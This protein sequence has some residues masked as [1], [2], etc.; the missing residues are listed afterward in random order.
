MSNFDALLAEL[1][2]IECDQRVKK[3]VFHV[4]ARYAGREMLFSSHAFVR[5]ERRRLVESLMNQSYPR[6]E[7]VRMLSARWCVSQ[8]TVRRC[9]HSLHV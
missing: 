3:R 8:R 5:H 9:L 1:D 4:L 6:N 2:S 7:I